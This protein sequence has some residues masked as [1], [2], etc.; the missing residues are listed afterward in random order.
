MK[1]E[2]SLTAPI[3]PDTARDRMTAC[4][5]AA[6][7]QPG[8]SSSASLLYRRGSRWGSIASV[9]PEDW[10]ATAE[11]GVQAGPG[12][13]TILAVTLEVNTALQWVTEK[14]RTFWQ[15]EL[16]SL[17]TALQTEAASRAPVEQARQAALFQTL[18]ANLA[19]LLATL[20]AGALFYGIFQRPAALIPGLALGMFL[21]V[22]AADRLL[23]FQPEAQLDPLF[24][25]DLAQSELQSLTRREIRAWGAAALLLGLV[26]L[27][28][29]GVLNAPWGIALVL[30]GVASFFFS[31]SAMFMV[32]SVAL[33][34]A[35]V[36]N[37]F[38]GDWLWLVF[39][40]FQ[41]LLAGM[42]FRRFQRFRAAQTASSE[43]T[44][45]EDPGG[46]ATEPVA[47]AFT[48]AGLGLGLV[49]LLG[50]GVLF[51]MILTAQA[52]HPLDP[53][54]PVVVFLEGLAVNLGVLGFGAGLGSLLS[55][56]PRRS[57]GVV[58]MVAGGLVVLAE[59]ALTLLHI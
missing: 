37:A 28:T 47:Q 52:S 32:Y 11:I 45:D 46:A 3:S 5:L 30:V 10:L 9:N 43:D 29:S 50:F 34:W 4:F 25:P 33:L 55:R 49:S 22:T 42:V 41:V 36:T 58:S 14:Q 39:A 54:Q 51:G 35:A 31:T 44:P 16:K 7:F 2:R 40:A 53:G 24:H 57:L 48:L 6:G 59:M 38:T 15:S 13:S 12:S 23:K 20:L 26:H 19:I 27:V 18:K 56:Y 1:F 8:A 17:E 21:G